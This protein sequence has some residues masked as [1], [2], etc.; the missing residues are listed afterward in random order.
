MARP[1]TVETRAPDRRAPHCH[2]A[3]DR[4]RSVVWCRDGYSHAA[5][6]R[7]GSVT[8]AVEPV[9]GRRSRGAR[10]VV[11]AAARYVATAV[12]EKLANAR[13]EL[14]ASIDADLSYVHSDVYQMIESAPDRRALR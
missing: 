4:L 7:D 2:G 6:S 12:A 14:I 8:Q 3:I 1:S 5:P 11:A 10:R 13:L 9:Y